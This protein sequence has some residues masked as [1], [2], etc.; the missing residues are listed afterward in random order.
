MPL[1]GNV[2]YNQ[3]INSRGNSQRKRIDDPCRDQVAERNHDPDIEFIRA[4]VVSGRPTSE[5]NSIFL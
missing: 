4:V 2:D 1:W 5:G 3:L